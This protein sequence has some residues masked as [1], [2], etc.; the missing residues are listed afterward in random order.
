MCAFNFD[1]IDGKSL[2]LTQTVT[3]HCSLKY[4]MQGGEFATVLPK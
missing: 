3:L 2:F 4:E 1:E